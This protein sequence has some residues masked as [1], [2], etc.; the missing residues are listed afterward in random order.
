MSYQIEMLWTCAGCKHTA[1][2]GLARCCAN[3]GKPKDEHDAERF[4]DDTSEANALT[5]E[6]RRRALAGPD[7]NCRFCFTVQTNLGRCCS[8]CG[9]DRE[10]GARPYEAKKQTLTENVETGARTVTETAPPTTRLA[11]AISQRSFSD[12]AM[13]KRGLIALALLALPLT[14]WLVFRTKIVDADVH[15]V[16][17]VHKV[18]VDRWQVYHRDG[19]TPDRDA[20]DVHTEGQRIHHYDHVRVGSHREPRNDR[21]QCG[22]TCSTSNGSCYTTSRVCTSNGNGTASCSGGSRVCSSPTRSCS[23]KYC[24][25]TIYVTVDDFEDQPRYR[26]WHSWH[27]WD[28]GHH[29]TLQ[30]AGH[31]LATS[32]P[33]ETELAAK[34]A[35]GQKERTRREAEYAV[36]FASDD[37]RYELKPST[38]AEFTKYAPGAAFRLK[39]GLGQSVEVVKSDAAP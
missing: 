23:P 22:E 9:S 20:F 33:T 1:N 27:V 24:N 4:P 17:W 7:W 2:R 11:Q 13:L 36:T 29:R 31:T 10:T 37:D 35:T 19:W 39:V 15:A 3:C 26:E 12:R 21:Y 38:L 32:W 14:M 25:R 30:H 28:W 8:N 5:G 34:L 18:H 16:S 6:K